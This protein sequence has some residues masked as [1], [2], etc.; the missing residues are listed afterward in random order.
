MSW[1]SDQISKLR[2]TKQGDLYWRALKIDRG[3]N[4]QVLKKLLDQNPEM[5][6]DELLS[7]AGF[8]GDGKKETL[9]KNNGKEKGTQIKRNSTVGKPIMEDTV[10]FYYNPEYNP[11]DDVFEVEEDELMV[12][13]E[14]VIQALLYLL[15]DSNNF[16]FMDDEE[17]EK[18]IRDNWRAIKDDYY[19]DLQELF[20]N[21]A[22]HDAEGYDSDDFYDDE[23]CSCKEEP[24]EE[25]DPYL[26]KGLFEG[27][28]SE[29]PEVRVTKYDNPSKSYLKESFEEDEDDH[30]GRYHFIARKSVYDA[31]G[32]TT[33]YTMYY[34]SGEDKYVMVF[35]D[36][37]IYSPE[38]E[39]FDAE[40]EDEDTARE[41]FDSYEGFTE[42]DMDECFHPQRDLSVQSASPRKTIYDEV[43][44]REYDDEDPD[45]IDLY[46]AHGEYDDD[47]GVQKR[48]SMKESVEDGKLD[49]N[50]DVEKL[51]FND[52]NHELET[53]RPSYDYERNY[54]R[55]E[56]Y[57]PFISDDDY[58]YFEDNY[59]YHKGRDKQNLIL[60]HKGYWSPTK[61]RLKAIAQAIKNIGGKYIT[62]KFGQLYFYLDLTKYFEK[63]NQA[64]QQAEQ[65]RKEKLMSIDVEKYKPSD[66]LIAKA[67]QYYLTNST[68]FVRKIDDIDTYLTYYY[69]SQLLDWSDLLDVIRDKASSLNLSK[70]YDIEDAIDLK[71]KPE[72]I[73]R[74]NSGFVSNFSNV[75]KFCIDNNI[76]W[77]ATSRRATS[78]EYEK[79]TRNGAIYT[80]AYDFEVNGQTLP[81]AIHTDE[82]GGRPYGYMIDNNMEVSGIKQATSII[83]DWIKKVAN[84]NESY[85]YKG[86]SLITEAPD[87]FGLPT[88][89]E[90]EVEYQKRKD[91]VAKQREKA[92]AKYDSAKSLPVSKIIDKSSKSFIKDAAIKKALLDIAASYGLDAKQTF[93]NYFN[94]YSNSILISSNEKSDTDTFHP[95][96]NIISTVGLGLYRGIIHIESYIEMEDY[97]HTSKIEDISREVLSSLTIEEL[98][99]LVKS[100]VEYIQ[101]RF[102]EV[103]HVVESSADSKETSNQYSYNSRK[104]FFDAVSSIRSMFKINESYSDDWS[105][106]LETGGEPSYCPDCGVRFVRDEEGNAVCP[107]CKRTPHQ[108]EMDKRKNES[109]KGKDDTLEEP[110]DEDTIK[111]GKHWVNKGKAGTHGKFVTKKAADAQRKAMFANGYRESFEYDDNPINEGAFKDI[112]TSAIDD[113]DYRKRLEDNIHALEREVDF[114]ENQAPKEIRRG[115]AFDSQEEIDDAIKDTQREL[116]RELAKLRIIDRDRR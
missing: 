76:Q 94:F 21:K 18:I 90:L 73:D 47:Y 80:I 22:S 100:D 78:R 84:I 11:E 69:L 105:D 83:I 97:S 51:I 63:D 106:T 61:E 10:I 25:I 116:N 49:R 110:L 38:D 26:T 95:S 46:G 45:F 7:A 20:K 6:V 107:E 39:E 41:W 36:G 82:G 5:T 34:D 91:R 33:D 98:L 37:D 89:D 53:L 68:R 2:S 16:V 30:E 31:D 9:P 87:M 66:A 86:E 77:K 27:I 99:K 70:Y 13:K 101:K 4:L 103:K 108:I 48:H 52:I 44:A 12:D 102:E 19:D 28:D 32:F 55:I 35:G 112:A 93:T 24:E 29:D 113:P 109:L 43:D 74:G 104:D 96:Y 111:Q 62:I 115:G 114:L 14:D 40:F 1:L 72:K 60:H 54:V 56:P 65:A 8:Q 23:V 71:V 58:W 59:N 88:D 92:Q 85:G 17:F 64:K 3:A 79:D 42:E 57:R 67:K 81:V 75:V 50:S 15:R